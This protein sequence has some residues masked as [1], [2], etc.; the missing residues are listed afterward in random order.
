MVV[1]VGL[2]RTVRWG[3][4]MAAVADHDLGLRWVSK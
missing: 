3:S 4:D 2:G 1:T